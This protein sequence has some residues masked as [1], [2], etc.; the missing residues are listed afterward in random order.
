[1]RG[2]AP[3]AGTNLQARRPNIVQPRSLLVHSLDERHDSYPGHAWRA[4]GTCGGEDD[5]LP[6]VAGRSAHRSRRFRAALPLSGCWPRSEGAASM[7][8]PASE[9]LRMP[10]GSRPAHPRT[11]LFRLIRRPPGAKAQPPGCRSLR[12]GI[13][14]LRLELQDPGPD[15]RGATGPVEEETPVRDMR[16]RPEALPCPLVRLHAQAPGPQGNVLRGRGSRERG[17]CLQPRTRRSASPGAPCD[18]PG[19]D[20]AVPRIPPAARTARLLTHARSGRFTHASRG[21]PP[22]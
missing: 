17:C 21:E 5:G 2:Q 18:P 19:H 1:M 7:G 22:W 16:L 10:S 6:A 3:S 15:C 12:A 20:C 9:P 4:D 13:H 8:R 11:S 14:N